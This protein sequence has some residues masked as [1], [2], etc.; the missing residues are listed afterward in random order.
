MVLRRRLVPLMF[1][2]LSVAVP[3]APAHDSYA[4][5]RPLSA[6]LAD[7]GAQPPQTRVAAADAIARLAVLHGGSTVAAAVQ[8][9]VRNLADASPAVRGSAAA[10]IEQIGQPALPAV[11]ALLT[12]LDRDAD[13]SVRRHA[14][15]ALAR[16]DPA[17][18]AVVAAA[19]RSLE[20]DSAP[21][22]RQA[23]A[24]ILVASRRAAAPARHSLADAIGDDD[25]GVR[26]YAAAALVRVEGPQRGVPVLLQS[27]EHPDPAWRAE[28][29][30]ILG[31]VAV[32][33]T[34]V[35]P[36]LARALE[37]EDPSVRVAVADAFGQVGRP[38]RSFVSV[39]G[40]RLRDPDEIVRERV[41]AALQRIRE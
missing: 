28:A 18:E 14:A 16:V 23:A 9:L 19:S 13:R 17:S 6:W 27:L 1:V 37:D 38:A 5:S 34:D 35:L 2:V 15:L 12:L 24:I 20:Q 30:G 40:A 22:V 41:A 21:G 32:S 31:E 10:A 11:D 36:A 8:P 26:L 29:A 7:L 25:A 3:A 39:L 4:Q 33:E